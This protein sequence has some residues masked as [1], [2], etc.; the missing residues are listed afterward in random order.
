MWVA[1]KKQAAF[2]KSE[3]KRGGFLFFS[4]NV[5][6]AEVAKKYGLQMVNWMLA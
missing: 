6:V 1:I 2:L 5:Y 4:V 3:I